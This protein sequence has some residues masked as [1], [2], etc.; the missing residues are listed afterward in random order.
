V[1]EP[2][3]NRFGG[4]GYELR[5]EIHGDLIVQDLEYISPSVRE[6]VFRKMMDTAD[7]HVRAKLVEMGWTPP[8][9][10]G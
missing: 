4:S 1:S 7:A 6:S 9:D 8:K 2:T 3:I 5:T 10:R